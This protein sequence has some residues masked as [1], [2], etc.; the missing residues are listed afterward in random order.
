MSHTHTKDMYFWE[1]LSKF[2]Q[3]ILWLHASELPTTDTLSCDYFLIVERS[4]IG[5]QDKHFQCTS[6]A[7]IMVCSSGLHDINSARSIN[8][9]IQ[10]FTFQAN[11]NSRS[12]FY[13]VLCC[14]SHYFNL[15]SLLHPFV[16][17]CGLHF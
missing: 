14:V 13:I 10:V 7:I 15:S 16:S 1:L 17:S 8:R 2:S 11:S 12:V 3:V 5:I 4:F 6:A 9:N